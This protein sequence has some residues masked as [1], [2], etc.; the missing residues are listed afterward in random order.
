MMTAPIVSIDVEPGPERNPPILLIVFDGLSIEG[1]NTPEPGHI[2]CHL[3]FG[4]TLEA[5]LSFVHVNK[6]G[7]DLEEIGWLRHLTYSEAFFFL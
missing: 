3:L 2:V 6:I 4:E 5:I 7:G 1:S